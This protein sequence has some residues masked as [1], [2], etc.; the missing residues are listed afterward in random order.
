MCPTS[1]FRKANKMLMLKNI[2]N[3]QTNEHLIT[4]KTKTKPYPCFALG[5]HNIRPG[6]TGGKGHLEMG[7]LILTL[8][9]GLSCSYFNWQEVVHL[10]VQH[11]IINYHPDA[12][13]FPSPFEAVFFRELFQFSNSLYNCL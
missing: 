6:G 8:E 9:M 5:C 11:L 13:V 7:N 12:R 1:K 3:K 2:K 4:N 10:K